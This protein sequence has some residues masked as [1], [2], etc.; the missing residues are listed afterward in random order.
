MKLWKTIKLS[1]DRSFSGSWWKQLIWLAAFVLFV[2]GIILLI[3]HPD[4]HTS[5]LEMFI[6]PG[7]FQ[8]R[9]TSGIPGWLAL[10]VVLAG[11]FLLTGVL[12]TVVSNML[13]RRVELF[14]NGEIYYSFSNH[15]IIIG[16]DSM[17]P[18]LIKQICKESK[19]NNSDIVIQSTVRSNKIRLKLHAELTPKE[20]KRI[21]V[22]YGRRDSPED[23]KNIKVQKAKEVFILGEDD[24][25]DC[26]SLNI[27]C[28]RHIAA[29]RKIKSDSQL[30]CNVLFEYQTTFSAFQI[31]DIQKEISS[32]IDFRPF[33]FYETWAQK[34][35]LPDLSKDCFN[36]NKHIDY[37]PLDRVA[38]SK[39]SE[40][41]VHLVIV[42]MNKMGIAL[43]LEAAHLAH[44]P[45]Y[46]AKGKKTKITF[47]DSNAE[48]EMF[49]F[50]GRFRNLFDLSVS[51]FTDATLPDVSTTLNPRRSTSD[52]I[53]I[54]WDFVKGN[55]ESPQ[56]QGM[57]KSWA[58]EKN[59]LLTIAMCFSCT[60]QSMAAGLYLPNEIYDNNIPVLIRQESSSAILE[61]VSQSRKYKNLKPFGMLNSCFDL[62]T[63]NIEKAQKVN[64]IYDYYYQYSLNPISFPA[65]SEL[66][67]GWEK[68][69]VANKWSNIYNANSIVSKLRSIGINDSEHIR[70]LSHDEILILADI[71]HNRWNVEKLLIGFRAVT[72]EEEKEIE[73]NPT[74]KDTYK[75]NRYVH[76]DIRPFDDL[77]TDSTGRNSGE[78]DICISACIPLILNSKKAN[79]H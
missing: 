60:N 23:L 74:L 76:Y 44:F 29:I 14:K 70:E 3:T 26:D 66:K 43:A 39:D 35:F 72:E 75:K 17:V 42:G 52:F 49:F 62:H 2:F 12:V 34:V 59:S 41:S 20:E 16:F 55:I 79:G 28:M 1:F 19:Y 46:N 58:L 10:V 7:A 69:S 11:M 37:Q 71:E 31:A 30:I 18:S 63:I 40:K 27:D 64:Y 4:K 77:R 33:N 9:I 36:G 50:T 51:H 6:D 67:E 53:D 73:A 5:I 22:I 38:I 32:V 48:Q 56:I 68:L 78:Y 45:N 21:T 54:E 65:S 13:E 8:N 25:K 47:I 57:F 61:M 15:V 24:E